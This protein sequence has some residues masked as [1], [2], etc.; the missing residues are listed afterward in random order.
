MIAYYL[1]PVHSGAGRQAMTLAGQLRDRCDIFFLTARHDKSPPTEQRNGISIYRLAGLGH[2]VFFAFTFNLRLAWRLFCER[3]R[4]ELVHAHGYPPFYFLS[5]A[6]LRLLNKP[7]LQKIS[8]VGIDDPLGLFVGRLGPLR[9]WAH[10]NISVIIAPSQKARQ[11]C[12]QAP[13]PWNSRVLKIPNGVDTDRFH[14]ATNKEKHALR[15]EFG[16]SSTQLIALFVG[17]VSSRKGVDDL[18][19][20]WAETV[21]AV[22]ESHL[23]L[24]G[25][26]VYQP[27]FVV[28]VKKLAD[29]LGI[30]SRVSFLGEREDVDVLM[31]CADVF[32][33]AS[34]NEGMPNVL[35]EASSSGLPI[36]A[37]DSAGVADIVVD[38]ETG[39]R[40][41]I[42]SVVALA[43]AISRILSDAELRHRMSERARD[44]ACRSFSI[45]SVANRYYTLY[46]NLLHD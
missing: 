8:M 44:R 26:L 23:L 1:P 29:E 40:V 2:G 5:L 30:A 25:P 14:P 6:V 17:I 10:Q 39:F 16:L 15:E 31:R 38:G 9:R 22:P 11:L 34:K 37:Y 43:E 19:R 4:Y 33:L 20:A 46:Q 36:V 27:A 12:E 32:C 18:L 28:D 21:Q 7:N 24:A 35:L 45:A 41:P 42:G 13:S 3:N